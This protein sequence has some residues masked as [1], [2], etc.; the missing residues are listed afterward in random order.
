MKLLIIIFFIIM[1]PFLVSSIHFSH[2]QT[3]STACDQLN[4]R[5]MSQSEQLGQF[6]ANLT[7]ARA[8]ED[9]SNPQILKIQSV[10]SQLSAFH[11]GEM[12]AYKIL[13]TGGNRTQ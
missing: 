6:Q 2:A 7:T 11:L 1:S 5:L 4:A 3:S 13:C 12:D 8:N 9:P 10:I